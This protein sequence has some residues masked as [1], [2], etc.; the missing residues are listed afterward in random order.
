MRA[1]TH[2]LAEAAAGPEVQAQLPYWQ[3]Q[4]THT[5]APLLAERPL[6]AR[7][8]TAGRQRRLRLTLPAARTAPLLTA[9]PAARRAGVDHVLLTGLAL[10]V[11]DR[12]RALHGDAAAPGLLL[13]LEGHGRED[14]LV[15]GAD[16]A[17]TVGWLTT[18]FPLHL[19]LS[20]TEDTGAALGLVKE[21]VRALPAAGAGWGLLRHLDAAG[22]IALAEAPEP[23]LLFNYLG[24]FTATGEP[25]TPAPEAGDAITATTDPEQPCG[26]ALEIGAFVHDRPEGPE[27][28]VQ[29]G[30]P[31]DLFTEPE[32]QELAAAWFARLD[33]LTRWAARPDAAAL[34]PS[35]V[36]LAPVTQAD[37]DALPGVED[38]LPLSPLQE[39]LLFHD[40]MQ[41]GGD[42]ELY[43]SLT[44]LDLTGPL[45]RV[46]LVR[47][48]DR[49]VNRHSALRAAFTTTAAGDPVQTVAARVRVPWTEHD[50]TGLDEER[51]DAEA[52]RVA[53]PRPP[54]ASTWP[55]RR[56][57][58]A[59]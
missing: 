14:R 15:P 44:A 58:A 47:A 23:R 25:W 54:A 38:V 59:P 51:R 45:D 1:W 3:Q 20:G 11:R 10:A 6:D 57:C 46:A 33:A 16:T 17:R 48:V 55:A 26:H 50:L 40:R 8:D 53:R 27:L 41:H 5:P 31:E 18:E 42:D 2:G 19:D 52:A 35:D 34:T 4:L 13:R 30:W 9:V 36:P 49:V 28:T 29:L 39:G 12:R 24:R 7:R 37:L 43:T 56:C 32:M 21:A 22:A